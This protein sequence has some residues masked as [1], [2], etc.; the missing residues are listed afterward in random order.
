MIDCDLTRLKVGVVVTYR[1]TD[2]MNY[3]FNLKATMM[4]AEAHGLSNP[5]VLKAA[6]YIYMCLFGPITF[7]LKTVFAIIKNIILSLCCCNT[8]CCGWMYKKNKKAFK[9]EIMK[10]WI[11]DDDICLQ[12]QRIVKA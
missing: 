9:K 6:K 7:I 12:T 4:D 5:T 3:I 1:I 11:D 2:L 10:G 8:W